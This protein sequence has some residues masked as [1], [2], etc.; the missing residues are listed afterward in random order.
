MEPLDFLAQQAPFDRLDASG[1]RLL[2]DSLEIAYAAAGTV[3]LR[4]GG[5]PAERLYVVR[6]GAVRLERDGQVQ[7]VIEA[8][9]CFAFPSLIGHAAP[10]A[11]VIA[12]DE[13]LLYQVP[14]E[15]FERLMEWRA[16]ADFFLL[17]LGER[18][19]RAAAVGQGAPI[20]AALG[21]LVRDLLAAAP[22]V[23]ESRRSPSARRPR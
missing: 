11:D 1:R 7:Q 16:F 23:V 15:T 5:P 3:I 12:A 17:D 9:E 4:R 18:L 20:G 21:A 2:G 14:R 13:T 6:K 10:T 19:R 22:V 8:G